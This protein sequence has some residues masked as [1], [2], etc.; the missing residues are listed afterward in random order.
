M[1]SCAEQQQTLDRAADF[2]YLNCNPILHK[3][4][5]KNQ[6]LA[7]RKRLVIPA[8]SSSQT[9][10]MPFGLLYYAFP[11]P[12]A[13]L[14][15]QGDGR[16][17]RSRPAVPAEDVFV[18]VLVFVP[19]QQRRSGAA[20]ALPASAR[21]AGRGGSAHSPGTS[22]AAA[23]SL[24]FPPM[25]AGCP[26]R[27]TWRTWGPRARHPSSAGTC[28][29]PW[30]GGGLCGGERAVSAA[31]AGGGEGRSGAAEPAPPAPPTARPADG[32][33]APR[34]RPA[35]RARADPSRAEP[36]LP[37]SA[38][39]VRRCPSPRAAHA[40]APIAPRTALPPP[41]PRPHRACA[42]AP[43]H[44][45][46]QAGSRGTAPPGGPRGTGQRRCWETY[47]VKNLLYNLSQRWSALPQGK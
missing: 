41:R 12:H 2:I 43:G 17:P 10:A 42:A 44:G 19:R 9:A 27:L 8:L 16:G 40:S 45:A 24:P 25:A 38:V 1:T 5:K 4:K 26:P 39:P 11:Q 14:S 21:P 35:R 13:P 33:A 15:R 31:G 37:V 46:G 23:P 6:N 34:P 3:G 7:Q 32:S 36:C 29:P 47:T 30:L 18:F 28:F 22:R 20:R